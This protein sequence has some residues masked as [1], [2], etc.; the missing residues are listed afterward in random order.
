MTADCDDDG[1]PRTIGGVLMAVSVVGG[2]IS[3]PALAV[4]GSDAVTTLGVPLVVMVGGTTTGFMIHQPDE[5]EIS[6]D[7]APKS[8]RG[9]TIGLRVGSRL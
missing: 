5:V 8:S 7:A 4:S 3:I 9:R 2:L 6:I 1:G